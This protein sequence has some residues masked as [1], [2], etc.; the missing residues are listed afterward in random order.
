MYI[1][2]DQWYGIIGIIITTSSAIYGIYQNKLKK[3]LQDEI[4]ANNWYMYDKSILT[5]GLIGKAIDIYRSKHVIDCDVIEALAKSQ[6]FAQESYVTV[7]KQIQSVEPSFQNEDI[8]QWEREGKIRSDKAVL[9]KK[10]VI[11]KKNLKSKK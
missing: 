6:I 8:D 7:I 10:F 2:E 11:A 1:T 9:F 4:R 5:A 3:T